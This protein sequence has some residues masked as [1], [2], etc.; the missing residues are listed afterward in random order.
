MKDGSCEHE[1]DLR[2]DGWVP[3]ITITVWAKDGSEE[4]QMHYHGPGTIMDL[5]CLIRY[6]NEKII[7]IEEDR[8]THE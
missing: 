6:L 1:K 8:E 5:A 7:G 2:L 4:R 3:E